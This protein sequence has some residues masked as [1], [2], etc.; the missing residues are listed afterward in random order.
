M[1]AHLE[2]RAGRRALAALALALLAWAPVPAQ[3]PRPRL[4]VDF[5]MRGHGLF[6]Y[7][8][9]AVR[10]SGDGRRVFFEWKRHDE[11]HEKDYDTYVAELGS[12]E[13]RKLS[14]EEVREAP[15]AGGEKSRD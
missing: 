4:T 11:P 9:R 6:G 7:E 15:P 3:S 12:S 10:W 1:K 13:P 5:V 8:P 14:E 2:R